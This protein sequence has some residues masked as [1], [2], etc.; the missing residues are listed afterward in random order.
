MRETRVDTTLSRSQVRV[1]Q[2]RDAALDRVSFGAEVL[3]NEAVIRVDWVPMC[4]VIDQERRVVRQQVTRAPSKGMLTAEVVVA[5]VSAAVAIGLIAAHKTHDEIGGPVLWVAAPTAAVEAVAAID[6]ATSYSDETRTVVKDSA[7]SPEH[8]GRCQ[9]IAPIGHSVA[10]AFA[11]A[12]LEAPLDPQ[13]VARIRIPDDL[14]S[15]AG[16]VLDVE[17]RMDE[18]AIGRARLVKAGK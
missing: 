3:G 16:G 8:A 7:P 10:L 14:W 9:G 2:R 15:R 6:D 13:G 12:T 5:S 4:R 18:R 11:G 17:V 1:A